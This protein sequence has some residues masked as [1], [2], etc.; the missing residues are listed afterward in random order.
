[1]N[2]QYFYYHQC[3]E[4]VISEK[5]FLYHMS[6]DKDVTW[7]PHK[8][9]TY[10]EYLSAWSEHDAVHYLLNYPF[11]VEGE[12]RVAHVEDHCQTGW[13]PYGDRF[14]GHIKNKIISELPKGFGRL[15]ILETA[16]QLREL[17]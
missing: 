4:K 14:N 11:T 1:M 3:P 8:D 5:H 9:F 15:N 6:R 17:Y 16:E 2:L 13:A 10:Q 7:A 12:R